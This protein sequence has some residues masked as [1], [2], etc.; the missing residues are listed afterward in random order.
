MNRLLTASLLLA[1][2]LLAARQANA[3]QEI[4]PAIP[5]P[6]LPHYDPEYYGPDMPEPWQPEPLYRLSATSGPVTTWIEKAE[7]TDEIVIQQ[8]QSNPYDLLQSETV[9][10]GDFAFRLANVGFN[11]ISVSLSP[12]ITVQS[13]TKLF[14]QSQLGYAT[15]SQ[16]AR[17]QIVA[18]GTP[19]EIWS[20]AGNSTGSAPTQGGFELVTLDLAAFVG[21]TVTIRFFYD[22]TGGSAFTQSQY[23]WVIDNIQV[24]TELATEPYLE[25][26][27]PAADEILIVEM[28]NRARADAVAEA[29]RLRN[30]TDSFVLSAIQS[31]G[32]DLDLMEQQFAT[33]QR[34]TRPLAINRRLTAA[35]RLHSF[36]M[37]DNAFQGHESSSS[38]PDPYSPEDGPGQRATKNGFVGSVGEN[39]YAFAKSYEHMHAGFNIDWGTSGSTRQSVGGMQDPP[40]HRNNIHEPDHREIG[41]GIIHGTNEGVGPMLVTQNMGVRSGFDSPFLVGV[42]ILDAD[43]DSFYDIDEGL[44]DVRVEVDGALFYTDS[45]SE[46]AYALPLPGDGAYSVTFSK[47][48]YATQTI[49]FAVTAGE[50][51]KIDYFAVVAEELDTVEMLGVDLIG[52]D[53]LRMRVR[54]TGSVNDLV[55]QSSSTLASQDWMAIESVVTDLGQDEYQIDVARGA[56]PYFVRIMAM[57]DSS[58]QNEY[59]YEQ[60]Q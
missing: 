16:V 27:D 37:L 23:G 32:V 49:A 47:T 25:V 48:G 13:G 60:S 50:S 35:T 22:F 14:F 10:Q 21:Q 2:T 29:T 5:A 30:S 33:L 31:F 59:I 44:G 36:D 39:V 58:P 11:D 38:P 52:T 55:A 40:G 9:A 28:I 19:T 17:V 6:G 56:S 34:T 20:L 7:S 46:G 3:E 15:P 18:N 53:T 43:S 51:V 45:S 8:S 57:Q 24:G 12:T 54:Y 4:P 41:V 26:G 1:T 42:T